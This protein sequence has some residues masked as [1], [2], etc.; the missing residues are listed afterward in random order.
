MGDGYFHLVDSQT[1]NLLV[2]N[3]L[4]FTGGLAGATYGYN[5]VI[6]VTTGDGKK[7]YKIQG[8]TKSEVATTDDDAQGIVFA[9]N[10][11]LISE[12]DETTGSVSFN[13]LEPAESGGGG[14]GSS[15]GGGGG[16]FIGTSLTDSDFQDWKNCHLVFLFALLF[17][18]CLAAWLPKST[19]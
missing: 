8:S 5:N 3:Y 12:M 17:G 1:G 2:Q 4:T 9:G 10:P 13:T 18:I 19:P 7:V 16:C 11:L 14:G 6:Y 15:G